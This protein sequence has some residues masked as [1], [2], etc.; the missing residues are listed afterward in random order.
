MG[1]N[2]RKTTIQINPKQTVSRHLSHNGT[3][4]GNGGSR[5]R[6]IQYSWLVILRLVTMNMALNIE[7]SCLPNTM[8]MN[9]RWDDEKLRIRG[10]VLPARKHGVFSIWKISHSIGT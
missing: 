9:W 5:S 1:G 2:D 7:L 10:K 4:F 3:G 6:A 8:L